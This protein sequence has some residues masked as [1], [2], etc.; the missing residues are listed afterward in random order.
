MNE[1][2][3]NKIAADPDLKKRI[4]LVAINYFPFLQEGAR[5]ELSD[6]QKNKVVFQNMRQEIMKLEGLTEY[7][8]DEIADMVSKSYIDGLND[9]NQKLEKNEK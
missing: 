7:E 9:H 3:K 6:L 2:L 8:K 4:D 5:V 1:E